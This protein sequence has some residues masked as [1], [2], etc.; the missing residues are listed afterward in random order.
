MRPARRETYGEQLQEVATRGSEIK[1]LR[2]VF[3]ANPN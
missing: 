3:N 2:F 1:T